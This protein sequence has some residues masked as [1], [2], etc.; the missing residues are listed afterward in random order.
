MSDALAREKRRASL[1]SRTAAD[2]EAAYWLAYRL[3]LTCVHEH[4][5][6]ILAGIGSEDQTRDARGRGYRDGR[7]WVADAAARSAAAVALGRW[8][9]QVRSD[10]KAAAAR[11]NGAKSSGRPRTRE[12]E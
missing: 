3:G 6:A 5:A 12:R 4:E 7:A 11:A 10:A 1:L 9:G 8:G 2:P